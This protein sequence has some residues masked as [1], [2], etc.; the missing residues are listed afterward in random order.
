ML[1]LKDCKKVKEI[2]DDVALFLSNVS[3]IVIENCENL[4]TISGNF[5]QLRELMLFDC[6]SIEFIPCY[7]SLQILYLKDCSKVYTLPLFPNLKELIFEN[8]IKFIPNFPNLNLL[9]IKSNKNLINLPE[10]TKLKFL[11]IS[12][13]PKLIIIP[14]NKYCYKLL[15]GNSLCNRMFGKSDFFIKIISRVRR[16]TIIKIENKIG[17]NLKHPLYDKNIWKIVNEFL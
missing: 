4:K 8:S 16:K 2:S 14:N 10:L 9:S 6:S 7:D 15:D 1:Y 5:K 11:I 13:C 3:K 17:N 12:D